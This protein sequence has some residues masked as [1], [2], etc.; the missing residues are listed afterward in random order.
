MHLGN[1]HVDSPAANV[2][3]HGNLDRWIPSEF[4]QLSS[5][6]LGFFFIHAAA[7]HV[8]MQAFRKVCIQF[9]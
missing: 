1:G 8:V 5:A 6:K 3:H 9:L 2:K 4:S 7:L